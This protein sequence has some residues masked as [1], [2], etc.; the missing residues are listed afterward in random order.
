MSVQDHDRPT[1]DGS[2]GRL[3]RPVRPP[4]S[5]APLV[6]SELVGRLAD[7][8]VAGPF[9]GRRTIARGASGV[10]LSQSGVAADLYDISMVYADGRGP[11]VLVSAQDD[12]AVVAQWRKTAMAFGLP[13][14]VMRD[15]GAVLQP[16]EHCGA[17]T[18]GPFRYRR[19]NAT[20]RRRRP[21]FL[22]RRKC[23]RLPERPLVRRERDMSPDAW[24][25]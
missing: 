8:V 20:L 22:Q 25:R 15:D 21:R 10:L 23:G 1:P 17:V 5:E 14:L 24:T 3:E 6:R 7:M 18:V 12:S 13:L 11:A 9:A 19:R 4:A 2:A 16:Y